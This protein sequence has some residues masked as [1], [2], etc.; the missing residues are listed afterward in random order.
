MGPQNALSPGRVPEQSMN[1]PRLATTP[2]RRGEWTMKRSLRYLTG[3]A[4][5][6]AAGSASANEL[7]N[8]SAYLDAKPVLTTL[9]PSA[10]ELAN[11]VATSMDEQR[12]VPT[13]LWAEIE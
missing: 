9:S 11:Q 3:I 2:R 8:Y 6:L 10:I 7:P 1:L 4:A 13:F 5:L 12:G